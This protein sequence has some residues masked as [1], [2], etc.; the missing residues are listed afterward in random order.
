MDRWVKEILKNDSKKQKLREN[1]YAEC[2]MLK[3]MHNSLNKACP[4]DRIVQ[5]LRDLNSCGFVFFCIG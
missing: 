3:H 4:A 2:Q 1:T 5:P